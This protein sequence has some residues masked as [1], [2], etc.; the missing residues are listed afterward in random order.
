MG[1]YRIEWSKDRDIAQ[2]IITNPSVWPWVSDDTCDINSFEHPPI[3]GV[4]IRMALCYDG[5]SLC[6]CFFLYEKDE[7]TTEIHT[8][9]TVHGKAKKFG[10]QVVERIFSDTDYDQVVTFI[11]VDNPAAASLA[12]KCGFIFTGYGDPIIKNGENVAVELWRLH[13]CQQQ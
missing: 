13:K 3:D 5:E 1:C 9:L 10:D 8:C 7:K 6:G 2:S 4:C 12:K 11:P